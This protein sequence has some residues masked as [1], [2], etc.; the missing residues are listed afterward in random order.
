MGR[1]M[2][3]GWAEEDRAETV[4]SPGSEIGGVRGTW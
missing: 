2:V 1:L 3:G 4:T